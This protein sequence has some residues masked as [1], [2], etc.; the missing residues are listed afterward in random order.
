MYNR[1]KVGQV[2]G[3]KEYDIN[4]KLGMIYARLIEY[5]DLL[6]FSEC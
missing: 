6:L 3:F 5:S 2:P 1:T 4:V